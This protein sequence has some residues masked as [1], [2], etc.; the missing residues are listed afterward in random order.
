MATVLA[1]LVASGGGGA[2]W[3]A[4]TA[5]ARAARARRGV[6]HLS[7]ESRV[8]CGVGERVR[9]LFLGPSRKGGAMTDEANMRGFAAPA[10]PRVPLSWDGLVMYGAVE[11]VS[12][13]EW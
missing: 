8:Q 5:T 9:G 3:Q 7:L 13:R 2:D 10:T 1:L 4:T 11:E 6:S 12:S